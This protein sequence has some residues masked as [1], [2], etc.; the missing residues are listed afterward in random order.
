[1]SEKIGFVGVGR[2]GANMARRLKECGHTISALYDVRHE[3]AA[4]LAKEIGSHACA[5][6]AEVTKLSSLII[7]V[8]NDDKSMKEI[9]SKGLLKRAKG[10]IFIN[11]ATISPDTH[12]WVEEKAAKKGAFT[13]EA[14]MA[15]SINQARSGTLY[16]M[17]GGAQAT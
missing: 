4:E 17:C 14:C 11:C 8:V 5:D 15:S 3:A 2:M 10:R 16:L 9:F 13:L 6:L 1:M 7:T 12:R